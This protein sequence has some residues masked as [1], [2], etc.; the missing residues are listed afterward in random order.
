[1]YGREARLPVDVALDPGMVIDEEAEE[2]LRKIQACR[3]E[4]RKIIDRQQK[5][6]KQRYDKT[7]RFVEYE[8]GDLLMVW[9]LH[10]SKSKVRCQL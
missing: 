5:K 9:S 6:Q 7:H 1:M 3:K 4:M 2:I 8:E 10:N